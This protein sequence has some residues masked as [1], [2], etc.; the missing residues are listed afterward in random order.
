M[1][2]KE[3]KRINTKENCPTSTFASV[4][5]AFLPTPPS[6]INGYIVSV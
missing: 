1:R 4:C 5:W 2:G 6:N 3:D